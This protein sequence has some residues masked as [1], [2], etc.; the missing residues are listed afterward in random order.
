LFTSLTRTTG[1]GILV[2]QVRPT[3]SST[4]NVNYTIATNIKLG[5]Q[6]SYRIQLQADLTLSVQVNGVTAYSAPIDSSWQT[7]GLYF[8]A[9]AYV[10]D[11]VGLSTEGGRVAFY[12]LSVSHR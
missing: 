5:A 11:N 1:T 12:A 10:Q 9:G 2:A 3:P 7:Q 6:F 4:S 8:K